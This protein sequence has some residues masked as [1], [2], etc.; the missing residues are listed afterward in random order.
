MPSPVAFTNH[1]ARLVWLLVFRPKA[2]EEHKQALRAAVVEG[3]TQHH[4]IARSELSV[5]IADAAALPVA[6]AHVPWLH[7]LAARM[8]GHSVGALDIEAGVKPA[9]LLGVA[10]ILASDAV[11]GDE[12]VNF[13]ARAVKLQLTTITARLGRVG[14]VRRPA[15]IAMTRP[16]VLAPARTPGADRHDADSSAPSH[17]VEEGARP[18]RGPAVS[19][20]ASRPARDV[21]QRENAEHPE[22]AS[23]DGVDRGSD[24]RQIADVAFAPRGSGDAI[25]ESLRHLDA[26]LTREQAPGVLD[27]LSRAAEELARGGRW[28]EVIRIMQALI[29]REASVTDSDVK[30]AFAIHIRRLCRPETL[31]GLAQ[32]MARQRDVRPAIEEI[33]VRAGEAGADILLEQLVASSVASERRAYRT[34]VARCPAAV[35]PLMHLLGDVRWYVVRNAVELLG[36]MQVREADSLLV[37]VLRHSDARVR[38]SAVAALARIGTPLGLRALPSRLDDA[39]VAV[40][41]QVV[42]GISAARLPGA[43]PALVQALDRERDPEVLH[44][45]VS[46]L[47]A[48][49]TD[50]AIDRLMQLAKPGSLLSRRATPLRVAA[51]NALGEAGTHAALAALR[52]LQRD[53]ERDV[54]QAVARALAD[55][56]QGALA[57]H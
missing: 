54:R 48:L 31:R 26:T 24:Q 36:E 9:D 57:V 40:R 13:D 42:H 7:E 10:R 16:G 50:E 29:A 28:G 14:F 5:A 6:P 52:Q 4:V 19:R 21:E 34:A 46:A 17:H 27:A 33:L 23:A 32:L 43:V 8:A 44:A 55:H 1:V 45:L 2:T 35:T 49:P 53:R 22:D 41:L 3:R 12:G 38:R 37:G 39:N 18:G 51:V 56:A 15:P 47:G 25:D 20:A 11:V 30:R